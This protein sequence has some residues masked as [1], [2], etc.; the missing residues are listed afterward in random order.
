MTTVGT[1]GPD[2]GWI[3]R[4]LSTFSISCRRLMGTEVVPE[5]YISECHNIQIGYL[6]IMYLL[7]MCR[8]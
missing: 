7:R 3:L 6:N 8:V 2:L 4:W 5:K 1:V